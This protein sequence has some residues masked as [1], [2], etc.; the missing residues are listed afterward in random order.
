MSQAP[1]IMWFTAVVRANQRRRRLWYVLMAI[2]LSTLLVVGWL[3][4]IILK[5]QWYNLNGLQ[6][7]MSYGA[8]SPAV[9]RA[10]ITM[11]DYVRQGKSLGSDTLLSLYTDRYDES[12]KEVQWWWADLTS[13]SLVYPWCTLYLHRQEL[14]SLL[15]YSQPKTYLILLQNSAEVR[16]NGWFYGS[17]V[18]VTVASGMIQDMSVHDSYEVPF[19]NSWVTLA[20]PEWT[21]NYLW[22]SQATFIAGN[23]FGFTQRDGRIISSV[24]DKI[25]N[26]NIDGVVFIS[27]NTLLQ[28]IPSL[29]SQLWR[30]QFINASVDLI[31]GHNA[32]FKKELYMQELTN[33][34][35]TNKLSL[36]TQGIENAH[37]LYREGMMQIY[38]PDASDALNTTLHDL[39]WTTELEPGHLYLRDLN[40]SY[41][42]IDTFVTKRAWIQDSQDRIM[43]ESASNIIN[44]IW[45]GSGQ[46]TLRIA[47]DLTVPNSYIRMIGDLEREYGISL[48][49]RERHILWL[50]EEFAYRSVVFA[51]T[52]IVLD[53]ITWDVSETRVFDAPP[54]QAAAYYIAGSGDV[55]RELV[56]S[57]SIK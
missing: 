46:Y 26:T 20:L 35:D 13:W 17:F 54:W 57:L 31:R 32:T 45:R 6:S 27:T 12:C 15:G 40:K 42:K 47:Y 14:L 11:I 9:Q 25:Y 18:R 51:G 3:Q 49:D 55:T 2:L 21:T 48:T 24:Y 28:M 4:R 37:L 22:D 36:I 33:Y 30:W 10:A 38:L 8:G 23:K 53:S 43:T 41:S 16:P 7:L 52:G 39:H 44:T 5:T 34:L 19:T 29:Q 56:I 1:N 50:D